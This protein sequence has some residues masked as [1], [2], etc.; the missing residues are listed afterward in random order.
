[1]SVVLVTGATGFIGRHC[2]GRLS[3]EDCE[4]HAVSRHPDASAAIAPQGE[5][6]RWH[7]ADLRDPAAARWLILAIR[8]SHLL[9][10]AWEATPRIYGSSPENLRWLEAG[11]AMVAA[12]GEAGG[13]RFVGAGSSAEYECGH[14]R[15][16]EDL[17]PIRPAT[18]YGK[19]KAAMLLAVEA[20]AQHHDFSAAWGRI[21][22][23][24]GPG[25]PPGRL[26]PGVL[27][28]LDRQQPVE[29]THGHQLRDFVFAPDA[30]DLLVR[31]M[32]SPEPGSFNIASGCATTVRSVIEYLAD[33]R[34]GRA[35]LRFGAIEP[36]AG[37]P[38]VLVADM[39]KVRARLGWSA[40]TSIETGLT[41]ILAQP[42]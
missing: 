38:P 33:G 16:I 10:L 39:T 14:Q 42:T 32:F 35:L 4:I 12:F 20:A 2:L 36:P 17:T 24:Y 28:A 26:I 11:V 5:R 3:A 40:P 18:I 15:C 27:A 6:V 22:L 13:R 29:T 30:A 31:L 9:H 19:C 23:P 1:M 34:G 25:D 21:F 8:P 41:Q 7:K 37:E